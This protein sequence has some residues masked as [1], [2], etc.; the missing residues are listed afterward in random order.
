M[1]QEI[2]SVVWIK[3]TDLALNKKSD[4]N[5]AAINQPVFIIKKSTEP[6]CVLQ[7]LVRHNGLSYGD[8]IS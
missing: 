8:S 1:W 6:W 2:N 5:N 7:L 4:H 3:Q